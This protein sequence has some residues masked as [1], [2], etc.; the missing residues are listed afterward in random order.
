[1]IKLLLV[2]LVVIGSVDLAVGEDSIIGV[3]GTISLPARP[4][5]VTFYTPHGTF[6]VSEDLVWKSYDDDFKYSPK[7]TIY[8]GSNLNL[9]LYDGVLREWWITDRN[10]K[11]GD[12]ASTAYPSFWFAYLPDS[13]EVAVMR[14]I[15]LEKFKGDYDKEWERFKREYKIR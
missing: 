13:Q 6:T 4:G 2:C 7:M 15:P 5:T 3:V 11:F 12:V 9:Q 10:T 14:K 1:M 8:K